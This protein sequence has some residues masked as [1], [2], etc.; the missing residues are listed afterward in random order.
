M[1][2][3]QLEHTT[4]RASAEGELA[5]LRADVQYAEELA[6]QVAIKAKACPSAA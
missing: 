1:E 5:L 4:Q 3:A 2:E 6:S